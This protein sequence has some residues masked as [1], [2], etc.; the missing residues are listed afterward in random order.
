MRLVWTACSLEDGRH[1][2][3]WSSNDRTLGSF[4]MTTIAALVAGCVAA[5]VVVAAAA[6]TVDAIASHSS[7]P[8]RSL[9]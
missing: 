2:F 8:D 9:F 3:G 7:S 4:A 6:A 1:G 5:R